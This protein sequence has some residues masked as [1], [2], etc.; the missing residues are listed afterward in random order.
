MR[1]PN[2]NQGARNEQAIDH[3]ELFSRVIRLLTDRFDSCCAIDFLNRATNGEIYVFGGALRRGLFGDK[4][5]G[6]VDIM[7]PNG[8][9]RATSALDSLK[10][11]FVLNSQKLRRYRWN[12]LQIDLFQPREFFRG[13]EDVETAL[14]F[15]DLKINA[16]SLHL[17]SRRI[18]DPFYIVSQVPVTDPGINWAR[19]TEMSAL[20]VVILAIRLAKIMH[21]VSRL[22]ISTADAH[23]LLTEVVPRIRE[24]DWAEVQ[25]RFPPGK[26]AFLRVFASNVL[27]RVD[28]TVPDR[29]RSEP[30]PAP[31]TP[32]VR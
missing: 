6:D 31:D 11:P 26:D 14:S 9:D 19:W 20:N 10:V 23:R 8:D 3:S 15:F 13:F 24:C 5:S 21:E 17:R 28:P 32:Y 12:S 7:V 25:Q 2:G 27:S 22:T 30:Q 1:P 18:V 29:Q 16:L 4:L